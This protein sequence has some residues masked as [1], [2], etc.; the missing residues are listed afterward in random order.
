MEKEDGRK[1]GSCGGWKGGNG[2]REREKVEI[3]GGWS[4]ANDATIQILR[5]MEGGGAYSGYVVA[6][7]VQIF[8]LEN[9]VEQIV[10]RVANEE[11]RLKQGELLAKVL[12]EVSTLDMNSSKKNVRSRLDRLLEKKCPFCIARPGKTYWPKRRI[13]RAAQS[14]DSPCLLVKYI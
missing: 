7:G 12:K 11:V 4:G 9:V 13:Y 6:H 14:P 3:C 2:G 1:E 5:V 10:C 8:D